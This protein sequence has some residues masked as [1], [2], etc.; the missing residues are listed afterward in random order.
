MTK[1]DWERVFQEMDASADGWH[2]ADTH[3]I[4]AD[5]LGDQGDDEGERQERATA[6][7]WAWVGKAD[8]APEVRPRP[9]INWNW[10]SET[11]I[12]CRRW[13]SRVA[14][15]LPDVLFLRLPPD[16]FSGMSA[17]EALGTYVLR[18]R[19][20][21]KAW[22]VLREAWVGLYWATG[23]YYMSSLLLL[24]KEEPCPT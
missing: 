20:R 11:S 21:Q 6:E 2:D 10:A 13:P 8:I 17:M 9:E 3:R 22:A 24:F 18:C 5:W 19:T 12:Q 16:E 15:G 14:S 7:F 1:E 4:F 23:P